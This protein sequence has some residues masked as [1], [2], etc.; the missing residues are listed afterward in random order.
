MTLYAKTLTCKYGINQIIIFFN[1]FVMSREMKKR[2][3]QF[4]HEP[5]EGMGQFLKKEKFSK[6][7]DWVFIVIQVP[8]SVGSL[9][10]NIKKLDFLFP[11]WRRNV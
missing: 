9:Q 8:F 6:G 11:I 10:C 5:G 7:G 3:H 4:Q 2:R 1:V